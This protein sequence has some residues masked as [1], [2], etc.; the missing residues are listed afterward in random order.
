MRLGGAGG[1]RERVRRIGASEDINLER[2]I[3]SVEVSE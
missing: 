1:E 3:I 2:V